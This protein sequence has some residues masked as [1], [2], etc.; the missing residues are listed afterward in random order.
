MS[1]NKSDS[2]LQL[3]LSKLQKFSHCKFKYEKARFNKREQ[4]NNGESISAETIREYILS[5]NNDVAIARLLSMHSEVKA[6]TL[7]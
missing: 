3:F 1:S 4:Q 6:L 5:R 7:T 2:S